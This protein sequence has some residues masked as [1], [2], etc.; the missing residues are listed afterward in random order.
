[1]ATT[2][3]RLVL[4]GTSSGAGKTTLTVGLMAALAKRGMSVQGFKVGPDYIDP[5]FH[6][7]ATGR[8]S[9]NLDTW[10]MEPS[11]MKEIFWRASEGADISLI[12][13][14]M[15]FYDGKDP[16]SNRG[17][18]AEI[19]MLLDAPVILIVDIKAMARSAA[20]I[21]KGFQLLEPA[22]NIAG[23]IANRAGSANHFQLVKTAIEQ[24][25]GVP[26]IGYLPHD[27]A[28][29][30]PER[31]LGL[32][33]AVERG[34]LQPWLDLL[35]EKVAATVD[36]DQLLTITEQHASFDKPE[37]ILFTK[38]DNEGLEPVTIAVA[39]DS[40]FHF[41]YQENFELLEA[42]GAK[43]HFF[44]PLA[45][46]LPPADADGLYIGGGFPEEFA[47]RLEEQ[48][49]VRHVLKSMIE[50][51]LPTFA[52][53]GGYMFLCEAIHDRAGNRYEMLG[54]VNNEVKMQTKLAAL[55]YRE[56]VALA[57]SIL[58]AA[59]ETAR[60][61]EFHYSSLVHELEHDHAYEVSGLRGRK[62]E[63]FAQGNVLAGYTHLH[64]ASNP[65]MVQRWLSHCREW[66]RT[67]EESVT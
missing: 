11:S 51:G 37:P 64:F 16:K 20:A 14:V 27:P 56:A 32:V 45:G 39:R 38:R 49:N 62:K 59:G 48:V 8:I 36:L 54:I 40:A 55:G 33:P 5:T 22:V 58:L 6:T 3:P 35:A 17:S 52:E 24:E 1:M 60:G 19:G 25:C 15:G 13:G 23:V 10:M 26:V 61:H 9:R 31:H 18:T 67:R 34:E 46:E 29:T 53:C 63:G 30:A 44:S 65:G 42:Y 43:L 12:E 41:Y 7:A 50:G 21:V 28:I 47:A 4:G 66:K 2:R 57:D